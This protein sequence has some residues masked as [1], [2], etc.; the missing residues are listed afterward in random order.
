MKAV[1]V[2]QLLSSL[3][4]MTEWSQSGPWETGILP[5]EFQT[6]WA[7]RP[8]PER[9][10]GTPLCLKMV[11]ANPGWGSGK[12]KMTEMPTC[13]L[14]SSI[15]ETTEH[16]IAIAL[17]VAPWV[18]FSEQ[19]D[20]QLS[21]S[22]LQPK[23]CCPGQRLGPKLNCCHLCIPSALWWFGIK[24]IPSVRSILYYIK[25]PS[26][27]RPCPTP[28]SKV[29][30]KLLGSGHILEAQCSHWFLGIARDIKWALCANKTTRATCLLSW[31]HAVRFVAFKWNLKKHLC[32]RR[33]LASLNVTWHKGLN[34]EEQVVWT[35]LRSVS[36]TI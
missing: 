4:E 13:C 8:N 25:I 26:G 31:A 19:N 30:I 16:C 29:S 11:L 18:C 33:T 3:C 1:T 14:L 5:T 23:S 28:H 2:W 24:L 34:P 32:N 17:S 9:T 10:Q 27:S 35:F 22:G 7:Q 12:Q 6:V 21:I 15:T 36:F 20:L